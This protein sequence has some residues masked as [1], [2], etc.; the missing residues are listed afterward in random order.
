MFK[1]TRRQ[2]TLIYSGIIGII[3]VI[4]MIS[5]YIALSEIMHKNEKGRLS[6]TSQETLREWAQHNG[7][8]GWESLESNQFAIIVSQND[9][10]IANSFKDPKSMLLHTVQTKMIEGKGYVSDQIFSANDGS[11]KKY[12]IYRFSTPDLSQN[13][14]IG[15]DVSNDVKL[16]LQM[17]WLLGIF[18]LVLLIVATAIGYVFAGRAMIPI[19]QAFNKQQE[20]TANASHEL[21]TPLSVLQS[22]AEILEEKKDLLPLVHQ[23]ALNSMKKEINRMIQMVNHFLMLARNDSNQQVYRYESFDL[24]A[25]IYTEVDRAQSL[26]REKELKISVLENFRDGNSTYYGDSNQIH[27][28]IFIL[29]ENAIKYSFLKGTVMIECKSLGADEF[30]MVISDQGC[31]I[32]E[33]DIPFIFERFYRVDKARSRDSG[34]NGLGLAIAASIVQAHGG[35]IMATSVVNKGSRFRIRFSSNKEDKSC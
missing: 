28:L 30:E 8:M 35:K 5:F 6:D 20:F 9:L 21:R 13:L 3:L 12:A 23:T 16:L 14:Y 1:R 4:L 24:L 17:K 25:A 27:Q 18:L 19:T 31:G 2:L 7:T 34:G 10:I 11:L 26:A 15:E 32:P 33:E 22:A 29:L